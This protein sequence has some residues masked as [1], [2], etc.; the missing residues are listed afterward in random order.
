MRKTFL[1]V[2][3]IGLLAAAMPST[4]TSCK[5]YDDDI[6][7]LTTQTNDLKT[8][9]ASVNAAIA[10]LPTKADVSA[11]Q[12]AAVAQAKSDLEAVKAQLEAAIA[13]KADK[14]TVDAIQ[15]EL[16]TIKGQLEAIEALKGDM[17]AALE[18]INGSIT[19][20]QENAVTKG[21]MDAALEAQ[22]AEL[23][24]I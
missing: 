23:D 4:F 20:L 12:A 6:T 1:K 24:S 18:A 7:N 10:A 2:A 13:G 8:Q 21:Q 14:A 11:A 17:T 5:D 16:S 15:T 3:L 9:L 19:E 22:K